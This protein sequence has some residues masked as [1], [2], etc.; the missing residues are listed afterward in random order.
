MLPQFPHSTRELFERHALEET[1]K[2]DDPAFYRSRWWTILSNQT[3][4]EQA[5]AAAERAG[6]RGARGQLLRRLGLR[7]RGR[8]F[9]EAVARAEKRI[10]A[11]VPDFR[12]RSDGESHERRRWRTQSAVCAGVRRENCGREH[13]S[14][15][16]WNRRGGWKQSGGWR[17]CGWNDYRRVR[18]LPD[19][20]PAPRL[21]NSTPIR[22]SARWAM[23]SRLGLP[24]TTCATCGF[25]WLTRKSPP[26]FA[27]AGQPRQLSPH[28]HP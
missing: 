21:R 4:I 11:R 20:M 9:V 26:G 17:S 12:R 24:G 16:R 2:S 8:I 6:F 10:R 28:K 13:H 25:C 22:F 18:T 7:A 15:Q 27:Q 19:S 1:P 23:R 3:A 5:S 14:A